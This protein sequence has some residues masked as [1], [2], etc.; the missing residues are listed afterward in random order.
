MGCNCSNNNLQILKGNTGAPGAVPG[1]VT[2]GG[3]GGAVVLTGAQNGVTFAFDSANIGVT[4][5]SPVVGLSYNFVTVTAAGTQTITAPG[6]IY[7]GGTLSTV[8][9]NDALYY[10]PNGTTN[11]II[12]MNAGNGGQ[13]GTNLNATCYVAGKWVISGN[14]I[15]A[16]A[17]LTTLYS[18]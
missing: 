7:T 14:V 1:V 2:T 12:T 6:A 9:A 5:P 15:G 4:L 17:P 11:N 8:T 18:G 13:P 3:A 10:A 16:L